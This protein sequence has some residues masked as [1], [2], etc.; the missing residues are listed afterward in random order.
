MSTENEDDDSLREQAPPSATRD[1]FITL[2]FIVLAAA[3]LAV[4]GQ[5]ADVRISDPDP[6]AAFWPRATLV[7][8]LVAGLL[9]LGLLYRDADGVDLSTVVPAGLDTLDEKQR[10]YLLSIALSIVFFFALEY[11][12]FFV[13][14]PFF[15]FAFAYVIG[16]RDRV[17][18][19]VFSVLVALIVFFAFRNVMN[20]A[21]PYGQGPFR[22]IST[23]AAN[24]F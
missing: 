10:Q 20:V 15:L 17:K 14:A 22:R 21:L 13:G 18:L 8:L 6:G 5:F 16:Y 7:V 3:F 1:M 9:N 19:L 24:L 12:G 2:A 23:M 4:S 11:V